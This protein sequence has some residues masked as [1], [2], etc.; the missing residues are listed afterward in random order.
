MSAVFPVNPD[1]RWRSYTAAAAQTV[2]AIP[3]PFQDA[4]DITILKIALNG[5]VTTLALPADYTVAG[6]DNP[7]GG[8]FTLTVPAAAGEKFMPIGNAVLERVLSIVRGGRYN[9][10]A[11]DEDLDRLM[12]IAQEHD[13]DIGR[14]VK[15]AYG[16]A[17]ADLPPAEADKLLGWN[18]D[19]TALENKTAAQLGLVA[20][21]DDP[22]LA[23]DSHN[24]VPTEHAV[25]GYAI[26]L[27]IATAFGLS[28]LGSVSL[29]ALSA[30]LVNTQ[31][32]AG[33]VQRTIQNKFTETLS[34][35]DFGA[36]GDGVTDDTAAIQAAENARA[37]V[38]GE[39]IFPPGTYQISAANITV[40]RSAGGGWRG[41][42]QAMLRAT[43]NNTIL[44]V[45]TGAVA[46]TTNKPFSVSGLHFHGGGFTGVRGVHE[47]SPYGTTIDGCTFTQMYFCASFIG[48]SV[49][50]TQTGWIQIS[51]IRQYGGGSWAFYGFDDTKYL[52]HIELNNIHQVGTG[53]AAN[54]ENDF[55][56]EG[57]RAVGLSINNC[58]SGSLD[59]GADG[60]R[61]RG[62]C[63]GVFVTN[64]TFVWPKIGINSLTWTDTLKPAYVYMANI[65]VDQHTTSA[66]EIEGRTWFI[67]NANFA[68]GYVRTNTGQACL[69]KSTCTDIVIENALFAYDQKSGLVVQNGA[70]K[71][72][73][74]NFTAE[75][76]NQVA[77]AFYDVDLGASP[78][79]DVRLFGKNVLGTAGV[80]AT[81]Q[82]VVNGVTSNEVSRNTGSAATTAVTT[83][84][85][86]MTY[87]IPA[88]VLKVGQKVR[89]TAWGVTAANANTKTIR[90]W[91]G[92]NSI[93]DHNG[94]W[95]NVPWRLQADIYIT[96]VDAQEY[97]G[98]AFAS[99]NTPS[100]RQG[101][102]AN[103]DGV[104][105]TVK[106]TGQNG[107]AS[108]GD[109][110]CQGF[111][112]E[113]LD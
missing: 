63:Q 44:C 15:A 42:G 69:L 95:N 38:A 54:W 93:V 111:T 90:L 35:K 97:S 36:V 28:L 105:I 106:C 26:P 47:A 33:A 45:L 108:A 103:D 6:A 94:A 40:N 51:N 2:F 91:F 87:S 41:R 57:R 11:T 43:A 74:S 86:L 62:D 55:W 12:I 65:G 48:G 25:K 81:G 98:V 46:G 77:G 21:S 85:D 14:A 75:N 68:N 84:E 29:P 32:G 101:T 102:M 71:I 70:K 78:Y 110:T 20:I 39:L 107:T 8:S 80:N 13:R 3:F 58:W 109:I 18:A 27:A 37:A 16:T 31:T 104:A 66:A 49:L 82:R 24:E 76:N 23:G 112:V 56:I 67:T 22:T 92:A 5:A 61:L 52:F 73:V 4:D 79:V 83:T 30:T 34:V 88:N 96:G 9:S 10:A 60:L 17:G 89:L 100:V 19:A 113:L 7:A 72:R 64:S 53:S 50:A 59:G 99:A 1:A